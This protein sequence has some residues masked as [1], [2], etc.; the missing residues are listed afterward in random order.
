MSFGKITLKSQPVLR[1]GT[2][3]TGF[4][5][6]LGACCTSLTPVDAQPTNEVEQLKKQLRDLQQQFEKTQKEQRQQIDALTQKLDEL[7]KQQAA[8]VEKKKLEQE[9]A[10]Q[11]AS[12][13]PPSTAQAPAPAAPP[14][15]FSPTAPLTIARAG[16]AYMNI[17]F[18]A[19]LDAGWSTDSDPSQF[20]ELGDHDP[21]KRGFSMRNAEIAVDGAVDPYFKGFG[22]IVLKLDKNN[23]TSIELEETYLQTTALPANLQVK[24][25]QFFTA[26]GRQNS[27]HPHQWAFVDSPLI[28]TRTFGPDGL[29]N[30]GAQLSWLAPTPFYS[31]VTLGVLDGQGSTAFSFRNP[32]DE[33]MGVDRFHGRTT[34]DRNLR[35]LQDLLYVARI[36]S[37]FDLTDLQTLVVG[38][39]GAFGPNNTAAEARTEIYGGDIYWKWKA[40]NS[41][42]GFPFVSWQTEALYRRFGAGADPSVGLPSEN[43]RDWGFY[44][45]VLWGFK[46]R[47]VAGLRGEYVNGNTGAYDPQDVFRG[48]R[49]RISPDI[50]FY[51]SEFSKLRVQYNYDHG[52]LFGTEHSVWFQVEFLLGAHGAHK[53]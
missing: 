39:S 49:T 29:R 5:L 16:S 33:I 15:G 21:I 25:G 43:L 30:L 38:A 7:M 35:G 17:S 28:L 46:L 31:E 50:S 19:L 32:G 6:T 41:Q 9:L 10:A 12:N 34:L 1:T 24:A 13:Q 52:E 36:S 40:R 20:L 42:G 51:P 45:Q 3:Y 11:L 47:W 14:T 4:I 48:E 44:S 37:S 22:N 18:D 2:F 26:F 8:E 23:E 27:Q 53:F